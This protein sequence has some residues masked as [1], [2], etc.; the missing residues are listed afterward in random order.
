MNEVM[1]KEQLVFDK[2]SP[3]LINTSVTIIVPGEYEEDTQF[4]FMVGLD[5]V[6][7]TL[8]E[9]SNEN[10][11]TWVPRENGKYLVM[12][13]VKGKQSKKPFD[14]VLKKDYII[15]TVDEKIIKSI[16]IDKSEYTIG[17]KV[18]VVVE[19]TIVPV[20]YRFWIDGKDGWKLLRDYNTENKISFT[21]IEP[22]NHQILVECKAPYS[23][24]NFDD[25]RTIDFTVNSIRNLEIDDFRCLTNDLLVGEDL[26]FKVEALNDD[27][28]TALYKFVKI[29]EDGRTEC[30]QDFSSRN[31]VSFLED[32]PGSYKLLCLV[33]DMYS[34][35]QYDDRA[36]ILYDVQPYHPVKIINFT[37]DLSSP[38]SEEKTI[39]INAIAEGGKNLLYRFVIDGPVSD[40]S[41]FVR[42]ST[43]EW[44]PNTNGNYKISVFVKDD[45]FVGEYE[46]EASFD[47]VIEKKIKEM[48]KILE[49]TLDR[50]NN[51]LV[52][53][54]I[55]IKVIAEGSSDLRYKFVIYKNG[56][57]MESIPY[58]TANWVNFTPE[59][60]GEYEI[61]VMVKSRFSDKPYDAHS[62]K[63]IEAKDYIEGSIEYVLV[64]SNESYMVGDEIPIECI[65]LN[66]NETLIKYVTRV[67]NIVIEE[68]EYINDKRIVF[69]PKRSGRYRIDMYAKSK[70]STKEFDSK[71]EVYIN[72]ID[73]MP[74]TETAIICD[75]TRPCVNEEINFTVKNNG[76]KDVCYEFYMLHRGNWTLV[77]KYS[78]KNYYSFRPFDIGEFKLLVLSKSYYKKCAYEDYDE[79]KFEVRESTV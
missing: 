72:I 39:K 20:M 44:T 11:C 27:D 10:K 1:E 55:N 41:G 28:R 45:S 8:A 62:L 32:E 53:K 40:D 50:D 29:D 59:K 5:G 51:F 66:S 36:V 3:Q 35:N 52:N 47:F 34:Q 54:P 56:V 70:K 18:N 14:S 58:G 73:A 13:Q 46:A 78:K 49:F 61:E 7:T 30:I 33:K 12:V 42:N 65:T 17:E 26:V 43:Y 31:L 2:E 38:Q 48:I 67:D 76:G 71:K 25:F 22:N 64:P 60:A 57:E 21:C 24:N 23:N 63:Y 6:W 19:S 68:T 74:I 16:Y 79:I 69:S 4:K 15:G 77:Q 37:T 75:N 9:F